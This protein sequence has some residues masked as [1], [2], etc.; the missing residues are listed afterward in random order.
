MNVAVLFKSPYPTLSAS[1]WAKLGFLPIAPISG[2]DSLNRENLC[3]LPKSKSPFKRN[4]QCTSPIT[5]G[6]SKSWKLDQICTKICPKIEKWN[7]RNPGF[8]SLN[9]RIQV[10]WMDWDRSRRIEKDW[11]TLRSL[12]PRIQVSQSFSI[13]LNPLS[14]PESADSG[15]ST[16]LIH[17]FR[18]LNPWIQNQPPTQGAMQAP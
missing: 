3:K 5:K 11:D 18:L 1:M 7:S 12:N 9:P 15:F 10:G 8:R 6:E 13:R 4:T 2:W 16:H 14:Q 17:G